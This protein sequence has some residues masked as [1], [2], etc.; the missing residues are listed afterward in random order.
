M[1]PKLRLNKERLVELT[2]D[3]LVGVAGGQAP[4]TINVDCLS[5]RDNCNSVWMCTTAMSCGGGCES[6]DICQ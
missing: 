6:R 5:I 4:P 2:T 3:E 1:H